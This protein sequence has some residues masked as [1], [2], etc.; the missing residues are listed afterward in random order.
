MPK[1]DVRPEAIL[2]AVKKIDIVSELLDEKNKNNLKMIVEGKVSGGKQIGPYARLLIYSP[3]EVLLRQGDWGG[4]N[5][6]LSVEGELHVYVADDAG[7]QKRVAR[8]P[9]GTCFGEMSI[10]AGVPRNATVVAPE[11]GGAV[12]VL[13]LVRPALRLLRSL[14]RFAEKIDDTYR[15]HGLGNTIAKI[16][17]ESAMSAVELV[18]LGNVA[19]FKAYGKHHLLVEEGKPIEKIFLIK[20][21]WARRVRGMPVYQDITEG[22]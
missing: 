18:A 3:G 14:R 2:E 13:E 1:E 12:T 19:Q 6:Y 9:P 11:D 17:E 8:I 5:F 4:N 21:G 16:Q 15:L 22:T 10:L 20:S 7:G